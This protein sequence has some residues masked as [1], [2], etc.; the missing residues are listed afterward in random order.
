MLEPSEAGRL[1]ELILPPGRAKIDGAGRLRNGVVVGTKC[2]SLRA[3]RSKMHRGCALLPPLLPWFL[4]EFI[5]SSSPCPLSPFQQ[6][7]W[8]H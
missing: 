7:W 8:R 6:L 3:T 2:R 4:P 5:A 1:L